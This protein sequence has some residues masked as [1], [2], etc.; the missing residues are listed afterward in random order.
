MM[1]RTPLPELQALLL[2][3]S[4]VSVTTPLVAQDASP[5]PKPAAGRPAAQPAT[6]PTAGAPGAGSKP[7]AARAAAAQ[8]APNGTTTVTSSEAEAANRDMQAEL[9]PQPGGLTADEVVRLAFENS[10]QL[11]KSTYEYD[12]AEI[13][14]RRASIAFIPR[15]DLSATYTHLSKITLPPLFGG[16]SFPVIQDQWQQSARAALP[17]TDYFLTILPSYRAATKAEKVAD[18]QRAAQQL[19]ISYE[20]RVAFLEYAR[21]RGNEA[22]ARASV[23]VREAGVRDLE[24]LVQAGTATQ[25]ELV[26]AQAEL[27]N[28]HVL[29]TQA[30]GG[31]EV[32]RQRLE[33]LIG[34][35]IDPKR[36]IGE[37]FVGIDIGE[38]PNFEQT[39]VEARQARPELQ[40][41][42]T[43]EQ[44][45]EHL[46]RARRG[47]M[48][49]KLNATAG[50]LR[51]NPN[52]R[53]IP[54][55]DEYR[56][57]W[58]VGVSLSWSPN[59]FANAYT[60][61]SEADVDLR[62][63][64]E[65]KRLTEQGIAVEVTSA[66]TSHRTAVQDIQAKTQTLEAARRYE[67]DQRALLLAGAAT[68]NDVLLA[69]R[70]LLAASLDWVNAFIAGRIA[71]A[72][73]LKAQGKTGLA[74][75]GAAGAP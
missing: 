64:R 53:Y 33:Q 35:P 16:F 73:L 18:K 55:K 63:V 37:P 74:S 5:T 54:A 46:V 26:R 22:V 25:T 42:Q 14:R 51:A 59:D 65:D 40:A 9:E 6:P 38:T 7:P 44:V 24:S 71:Q 66:V 34:T 47:G 68:P 20:A 3:A 61:G 2:A 52:Q 58:D 31:V 49:P 13:Q 45:R 27:A 41:L 56:T 21:L 60:Q 32:A 1:P 70:D 8:A 36:G 50:V 30:A 62:I 4:I 72:A 15:I 39:L 48:A 10:P 29:A 67:A 28:A 12:R 11:K 43:L 17:I 69:Q 75:N 57:T 23:R 19:Q